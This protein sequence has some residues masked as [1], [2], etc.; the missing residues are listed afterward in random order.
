MSITPIPKVPQFLPMAD[1]SDPL[2]MWCEVF[3]VMRGD[4]EAFNAAFP[5]A[6]DVAKRLLEGIDGPI[7][8]FYRRF[9]GET[10][11]AFARRHGAGLETA[12]EAEGQRRAAAE[13]EGQS[14][15]AAE[16]LAG[17]DDQRRAATEAEE[18]RLAAEAEEEL[19]RD[20]EVGH[21]TK[22]RHQASSVTSKAKKLMVAQ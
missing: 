9:L 12:A 5:Q 18:A 13:A 10:Y 4:D 21:K 19:T 1:L 2:A 3:S 8:E 6:S 7:R 14:R 11:L 20:L 17:T 16:R 15:A 22:K